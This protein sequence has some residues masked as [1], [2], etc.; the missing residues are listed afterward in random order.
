MSLMRYSLNL[1]H[2]SACMRLLQN[3]LWRVSWT[4]TTGQSWLMDRLVLG[5][6]IL[7]D[8]W[9][10]MIHQLV[11]LWFAQWKTYLQIYLWGLTLCQSH[12]C[13]FIWKQSR[14]SL[15]QQM[16]TFL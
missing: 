13:S 11:V 6:P 2:K 3:L 1:H 14:T 16:I 15:I 12:T 7:L 8:N 4:V 9:E 10:M 5:K